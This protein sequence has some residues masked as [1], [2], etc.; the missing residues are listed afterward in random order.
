MAAAPAPQASTPEQQS[1]AYA[2][3]VTES[4]AAV[5]E[6][7][8][9][10]SDATP[11]VESNT[12]ASKP[13]DKKEEAEFADHRGTLSFGATG[14]QEAVK[15]SAEKLVEH[16]EPAVQDKPA[17]KEETSEEESSELS[18]QDDSMFGVRTFAPEGASPPENVPAATAH[19]RAE[20]TGGRKSQMKQLDPGAVLI[21]RYEVVRRIGG[22]GMGAVYL[23]KDRNLGDAPRAVKEMIE[24]HIDASQHDKAINDFA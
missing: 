24:S 16:E 13:T 15:E 19:V 22:G 3:T 20:G 4:A 9:T 14:E 21:N 2:P 11:A 12:E 18:V 10:L 7:S 23:A 6:L 17:M 1:S 8:S 5:P